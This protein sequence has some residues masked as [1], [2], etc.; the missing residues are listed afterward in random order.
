VLKSLD[1]SVSVYRML[2]RKLFTVEVQL[3]VKAEKRSIEYL[4][5]IK[6]QIN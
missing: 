3:Q 2:R 1:N 4:K 5:K 6:T